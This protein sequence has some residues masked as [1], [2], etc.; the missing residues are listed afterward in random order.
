MVK[1]ILKTII[2]GI[3]FVAGLIVIMSSINLANIDVYNIMQANGGGMDT[4]TYL[5][6]LEQSII[7]YRILGVFLS[8]LGGLGILIPIR[9]KS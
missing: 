3:I 9:K 4:S 6:Y 5:I 2:F 7:N 1:S 8:A